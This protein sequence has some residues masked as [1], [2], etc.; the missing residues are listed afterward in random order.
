MVDCR[1]SYVEVMKYSFEALVTDDGNAVV[2]LHIRV[3]V[4][5]LQA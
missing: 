2:H 3:I 4:D 1:M 5:A